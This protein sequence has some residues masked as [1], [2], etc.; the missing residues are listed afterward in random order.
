MNLVSKLLRKLVI[1]ICLAI[2][3]ACGY[4]APYYYTKQQTHGAGT[5]FIYVRVD[6]EF[7]DQDRI[8]IDRAIMQWNYV[9]N[10]HVILHITDWEYDASALK[11]KTVAPDQNHL[12]FIKVLS[13]IGEKL[14]DGVRDKNIILAFAQIKGNLLYVFRDRVV[15]Q[16]QLYGIMM[17]EIAHI[18]GA[19]HDGKKLMS[20]H[21]SNSKYKCVD[22]AT[23]AQIAKVLNLTVYDLNWC[24]DQSDLP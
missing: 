7:N 18:F 13:Q 6:K 11:K 15:D 3:S 20:P 4:T 9:L 2:C 14:Y 12:Y 17:H 24:F 1:F 19:V 10:E 8:E 5:T 21:Y 16:D 23:V 22:Y